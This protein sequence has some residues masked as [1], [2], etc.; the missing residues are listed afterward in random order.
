[1]GLS[2]D[3]SFDAVIRAYIRENRHA[4]TNSFAL[5]SVPV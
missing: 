1:L 4:V 3:V 5:E 2:P